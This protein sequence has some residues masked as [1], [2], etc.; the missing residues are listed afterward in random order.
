MQ[1]NDFHN[2]RKNMEVIDFHITHNQFWDKNE[3]RSSLNLRTRKEDIAPLL[4]GD[5]LESSCQVMARSSGRIRHGQLSGH[6]QAW[7]RALWTLLLAGV[8]SSAAPAELPLLVSIGVNPE[9]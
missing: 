8:L 5:T 9:P 2:F 7:R 4:P 1:S 3:K 6:G